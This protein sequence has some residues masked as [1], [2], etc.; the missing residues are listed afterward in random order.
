MSKTVTT[1]K[2]FALQS[3]VVLIGIISLAVTCEPE[4]KEPNP[5]PLVSADA[6]F[7]AETYDR[8][9]PTITIY[10]GDSLSFYSYGNPSPGINVWFW[11]FPGGSPDNATTYF[12]QDERQSP[13]IKYLTPGTFDVTLRVTNGG[14]D[15]ASNTRQGYV[16]VLDTNSTTGCGTNVTDIDGNIYSVVKIGNQCWMQQNLKTTKYNDGTS[17][18]PGLD[19]ATWAQDNTGAYAMYDN[20]PIN[21]DTYGYSYNWYAV[22]TGKL[23]PQGWHIPTAAEFQ[24]LIATIGGE[25]Q[26]GALKSTDLWQT[27]NVGA[28]NS[29]GFSATG[30]G[31][32]LLYGPY[33]GISE[34][35]R[36]WSSSDSN[37]GGSIQLYLVN[38]S[39]Y[40]YAEGF[41]KSNGLS[42]RCLKD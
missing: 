40:V 33:Y 15:T 8:T 30:S 4:H 22:N 31:F 13:W 39:E 27:P 42:C 38:D 29:S 7:H 25:S 35:T 5:P 26:G 14:S 19:D 6:A 18:P 28:T 23:C 36:F 24:T 37:D 11:S 10:R 34:I 41:P 2:Y 1:T 3:A 9:A 17:I 20:D 32:R 16:T 21:G 12:G